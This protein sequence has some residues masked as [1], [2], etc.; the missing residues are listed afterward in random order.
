[1][2]FEITNITN[3]PKSESSILIIYTGGTF[4]MVRDESGTL[5]PFNFTGVLEKIPEL[6]TVDV[7][8]AYTAFESQS[9][10]QISISDIGRIL[11][12]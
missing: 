3:R 11:L 7:N 10:L 9:I 5:I 4:G 8:L 2:S 1:M 12:K 6:K